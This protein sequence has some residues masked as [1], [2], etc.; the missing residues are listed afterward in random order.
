MTDSW[1]IVPAGEVA[2]IEIGG[3]PSRE[4]PKFWADQDTGKAWAS[5]ADLSAPMVERTAEYISDLGVSSSNVKLVPAGTPMMSFKLTIGRTSRAGTDLYTNEAIASFF[6]DRLQVDPDWLF[7]ALPAAAAAVVTDVAI[8]GATLNKKSLNSM[9]LRMP[10][11]AE[12]RAIAEI[13]NTLDD[14]IRAS[15]CVQDKLERIRVGLLDESINALADRKLIPLSDLCSADIC[16]GIVQSGALV[17]SG[18]PVLAIRD[19][20]GDFVSGVHRTSR[21]IDAR[22]KRSRVAPG[23]VLLS[24]KGTIGRVGVA[25]EHYSGNIS[26]EIGRLRFDRRIN[27][28][29]AR[30]YFLSRRAQTRLDLAVV[31]TTR[32]EI[33]IHV[34]KKFGFPVPD[35]D[36]QQAII[37]RLSSVEEKIASEARLV[38][39]L[40]AMQIGLTTALMSGRNRLSAE[41]RLS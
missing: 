12:Q 27:P 16:Y 19:L 10:P 11:I 14:Q 24:I 33:S 31:G 25:P 21:S 29:F 13:L 38:A 17:P 41:V 3:T 1:R 40:R 28:Y 34:L 37:S 6:V 8:K 9:L 18:I 32:A 4:Q 23:D 36:V 5:I 26:R 2:R 15:R 22:Y 30:Q 39:K 20:G 7:H 35:P